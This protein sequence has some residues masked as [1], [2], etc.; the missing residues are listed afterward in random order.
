MKIE[1]KIKKRKVRKKVELDKQK[2]LVT[3]KDVS[4]FREKLLKEQNDLC[5]IL[6]ETIERPTLDHDH[7]SGRCRGVISSRVNVLEGFL[8][9]ACSKYISTTS[10]KSYSEILRLVADYWEQDYSEM[11][12]HYKVI[13]DQRKF[14]ERSNIDTIIRRAKED[15]DLILTRQ[16][17]TKEDLIVS[18][19]KGFIDKLERE[20]YLGSS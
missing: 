17:N 10:T 13:E 2:W 16:G 7:F 9:K 11:P 5:S 8:L 20:D 19:L 15:L 18:Y 3:Q 1:T 12:L 14:L 6:G 4:E